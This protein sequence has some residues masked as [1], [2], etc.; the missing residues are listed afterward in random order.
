MLA[1]PRVSSYF[2]VLGT[3]LNMFLISKVI[4]N[5]TSQFAFLNTYLIQR[6]E[7]PKYININHFQFDV[8]M[9]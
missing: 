8:I 7:F 1:Y 4:L 3:L 9:F 2:L 6:R 5:A